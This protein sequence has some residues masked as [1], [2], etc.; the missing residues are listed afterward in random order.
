MNEKIQSLIS[1][2][3]KEC[4]KQNTELLLG[5]INFKTNEAKLAVLCAAGGSAI[6]LNEIVKYLKTE[7]D[8]DKPCKCKECSAERE[9][10]R[11][12]NIDELLKLFLRGELR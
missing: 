6:I 3:R 8:Y 10:E 2:L 12:S 5:A 1:E 7:L 11:N 9:E 4:R